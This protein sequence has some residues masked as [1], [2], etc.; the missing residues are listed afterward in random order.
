MHSGRPETRTLATVQRSKRRLAL[1]KFAETCDDDDCEG[2]HLH[3]DVL[4]L[5]PGDALVVGDD[6]HQDLRVRVSHHAP[7]QLIGTLCRMLVPV[8]PKELS[9]LPQ[10][11]ATRW[12][13]W[14]QGE[15]WP[16]TGKEC[17]Q[18]LEGTEGTN[19]LQQG[20]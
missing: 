7:D 11:T 15:G 2:P 18:L 16:G 13:T 8:F 5:V 20:A 19:N 1:R 10:P 12:P 6:G 17:G 4:V 3:H 9:V 14:S